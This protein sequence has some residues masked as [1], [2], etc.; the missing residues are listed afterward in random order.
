ML[1]YSI[2]FVVNL[3][4]RMGGSVKYIVGNWKMNLLSRQAVL[5]SSEISHSLSTYKVNKCRVIIC[6][7]FTSL[8]QVYSNISDFISL[9]AQDCSDMDQGAYT[10]DISADMLADIG[11]K[12]VILGHSERRKYHNESSE[13]IH[14]KVLMA[15][16]NNIVPI[17]C[18]GESL[19]EKNTNKT[20][21]ILEKQ[22]M[23]SIPRQ[24]QNID[25]IVAYEPVWAIGSGLKPKEEEIN[26]VGKFIRK[27]IVDKF[28]FTKRVKVLY[29]GSVTESN[30]HDIVS[31]DNIDG[32]LVGGASLKAK[33][34]VD[35]IKICNE[36]S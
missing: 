23:E 10:G 1:F 31:L 33:S 2:L 9:G 32:L 6:P 12:Y 15:Y 24:N 3:C 16:K 26:Q 7:T 25:L 34:F 27:F 36:V 11:C 30:C 17:V 4:K 20:F 35:I 14:D 8:L 22:L 28:M 5:L 21:E 19:E 29:G 13:K 18:V